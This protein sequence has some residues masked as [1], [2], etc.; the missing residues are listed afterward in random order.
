MNGAAL[1]SKLQIISRIQR[2]TK[3]GFTAQTRLKEPIG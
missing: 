3:A 2:Y 1:S